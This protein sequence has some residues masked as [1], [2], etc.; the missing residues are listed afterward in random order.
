VSDRQRV[1]TLLQA[2]D[3][4]EIAAILGTD[5]AT[6]RDVI[7][8]TGS[9]PASGGGGSNVVHA[10]DVPDQT[11]TLGCRGRSAGRDRPVA[12]RRAGPV[13]GRDVVRDQALR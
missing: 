13:V 8:G 5:T 7:A 3:R 6:I 10:T 9:L 11:I 12:R 4:E 1:I 2:L